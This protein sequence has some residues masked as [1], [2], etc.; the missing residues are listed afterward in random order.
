[1][2]AR[3][4]LE[5]DRFLEQPWKS[6]QSGGKQY[7]IP[8]D[9][10]PFVLYYNTELVR[11][12]RAARGRQAAALDGADGLLDA[13]QAVK[14]ETG[15]TGLV[16]ETRGVTP[17]RIF[18][19]LYS[20]LGGP[21]IIDD[22]GTKIGDRRR[23]GDQGARVDGGA[24]QA[25]RR[26]PDVDYQA[27]G[28]VLRQRRPPRSRSTASG[29]SRPSRRRRC[30]SA[31]ARCRR[32]ST[33]P[34]NQADAHTFVIP[35]NPSRSPERLDAA[36]AFI[37]RLRQQGPG[38]GEGRPRP[39]LPAGVRERRVPQALAAERLRR[40]AP[41]ASSSTRSPGTAAAAR[42]SRRR[43]APRSSRWSIGAQKP[44]SRA[45]PRSATTSSA[46]ARNRSPSDR[47]DA[48]A[49]HR[50]TAATRSGRARAAPRDPRVEPRRAGCSP[51]RSSSLFVLFLFWPVLSALRTVAVRRVAG[52]RLAPGRGLEQ[53]HASCCSDPDFW[54]AMWHTAL[55]T[56]LSVPPLVVAAARPGAAGQPR[57]RGCSGCS[58][59]RSSRRSCCPSP[60]SC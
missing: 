41:S 31:C 3:H 28:R 46:S 25:R 9:T 43:P 14:D 58:G 5:G 27:L 33:R 60:S 59:S 12:G 8:L 45:W 39:R 29:R 48:V 22:G 56:L 32:S 20:Q 42:T 54:A 50:S 18:L 52:R 38:L 30:R 16:F 53:L 2:L 6:G 15:K 36:L 11:E 24:A 44:R 37:S 51:R 1:M 7:A 55:F 47:G 21:P 49:T 35:R 13:C 23:Q 57:A 40:G 17:W 10:H 34:A 19:T 26:R 4:G